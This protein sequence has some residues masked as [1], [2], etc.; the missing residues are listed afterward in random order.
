MGRKM[1]NSWF[2]LSLSGIVFAI[3]CI[4]VYF[5]AFKGYIVPWSLPALGFAFSSSFSN[6]RK[7]LE[8]SAYNRKI[9][10]S[11]E[12]FLSEEQIEDV[13]NA[14]DFFDLQPCHRE[15]SILFLDVVG[16]SLVA[17]VK[18]AEDTFELLKPVL[19][20]ISETV[21]KYGG[22]VDNVLGDGLLCFFG[23]NYTGR[24]TMEDHAYTALSCALEIQRNNINWIEKQV[25]KE[26]AI[27]PLRIGINTAFVQIGDLGTT[28]SF[29][30]T[31]IGDGVNFAARLESACEEFKILMSPST[32]DRIG[33]RKDELEAKIADRYISI[34]HHE[35]LFEAYDVN[36]FVKDQEG[37]LRAKLHYELQ[38]EQMATV[39]KTDK[40]R[41]VETRSHSRPKKLIKK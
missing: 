34:K 16:F 22:I 38:K 23:Y 26:Q 4:G 36:P 13:K 25:A 7:N 40:N 24:Q 21:H 14:G 41:H 8:I 32:L 20:Q 27:F 31:I 10:T 2:W 6:F 9:E 39:I 5:F 30:P 33:N 15:V 3:F 12:G 1:P 17:E 28:K 37:L 19:S 35:E 18:S 11:L 29:R